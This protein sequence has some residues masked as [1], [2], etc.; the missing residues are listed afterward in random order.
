MCGHVAYRR[1]TR[2]VGTIL[3]R[4][5]EEKRSLRRPKHRRKCRNPFFENQNDDSLPV[6]VS[7]TDAKTGNESSVQNQTGQGTHHQH[8]RNI[9]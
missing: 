8:K 3:N 2:N 7:D 9:T 5:S 1:E 6:L 4:K